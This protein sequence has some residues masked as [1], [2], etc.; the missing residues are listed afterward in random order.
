MKTI[1]FENGFTLRVT[2]QEALLMTKNP[3]NKI[4]YTT[5]SKHKSWKKKDT[6]SANNVN[7]IKQLASKA[8]KYFTVDGIGKKKN[9]NRCIMFAIE[10]EGKPGFLGGKL[11]LHNI[12]ID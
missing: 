11:N 4:K 12:N 8:D 9:N 6:Q 3:E 10:K 5:K 7:K 1:K 2:N